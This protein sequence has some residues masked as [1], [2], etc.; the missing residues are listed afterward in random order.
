MAYSVNSGIRPDNEK[1]EYSVYFDWID[2]DFE[3]IELY[4]RTPDG[5]ADCKARDWPPFKAG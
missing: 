4:D 5:G 3:R 2:G 1:P